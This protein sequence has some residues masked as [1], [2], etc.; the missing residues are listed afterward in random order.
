MHFIHRISQPSLLMSNI[1]QNQLI[2]PC[3]RRFKKRKKKQHRPFSHLQIFCLKLSKTNLKG[4]TCSAGI[5]TNK[6]TAKFIAGIHK[7]NS[8]S[9]LLPD[10]TETFMADIPLRK[11]RGFGG[12][13]GQD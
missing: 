5:S 13:L 11:L 9:T 2:I 8:Q 10:D 12:K 1:K 4:F 7:P 3:K 6:L